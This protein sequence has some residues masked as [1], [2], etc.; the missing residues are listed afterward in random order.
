MAAQTADAVT[1][2]GAFEGSGVPPLLAF[3]DGA[4]LLRQARAGARDALDALYERMATRLHGFIRT[5]LGR[6]LRARVES[7]DILQATLM[8]SFEHLHQFE[9]A[10]SGSLMAW[11]AR[12]AENEIRDQVEYHSRHRRDARC[13]VSL[14]ASRLQVPAATSS[15]LNQ[16]ILDERARRLKAAL[17][18]IAPRYRDVIMLRSFEELTFREIGARLGKS[19]DACRML[20]ARAM[21]A[22]TL[23]LTQDAFSVLQ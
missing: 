10:D 19:E 3:D 5:R 9:R 20:F 1:W 14:E 8:K 18:A 21:T 2:E 22:L 13:E 16:L 23:E 17:D 12:I 15:V 6:T 4:A 11:L 7:R